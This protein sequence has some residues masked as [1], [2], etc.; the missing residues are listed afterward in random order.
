MTEDI[1]RTDFV[2]G[3]TKRF[4]CGS[5]VTDL[6]AGIFLTI[7]SHEINNR[8]KAMTQHSNK[9]VVFELRRINWNTRRPNH[10]R[11]W[12]FER[13]KGSLLRGISAWLALMNE[14]GSPPLM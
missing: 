2:D 11:R 5:D 6:L 13:R 4:E 7:D 1:E 9:F 12:S 8:L 3:E 14:R 10:R